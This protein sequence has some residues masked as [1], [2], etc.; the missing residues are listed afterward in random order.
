MLVEVTT[1]LE[2]DGGYVEITS[3]ISIDDVILIDA[4]QN[5]KRQFEYRG[6]DRGGGRKVYGG[7]G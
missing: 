7:A 4:A 2:G 3:G 6:I 1:G 5:A